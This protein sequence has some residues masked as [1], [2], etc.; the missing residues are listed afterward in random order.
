MP[1][2]L[3][4]AGIPWGEAQTAGPLMGAKTVR[5]PSAMRATG[6]R[7]AI[8]VMRMASHEP[9]AR[10]LPPGLN[11]TEETSSAWAFRR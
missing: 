10:N 3:W 5:Y 2:L 8:A 11:A 6:I 9:L 4:L 7:V 1:P